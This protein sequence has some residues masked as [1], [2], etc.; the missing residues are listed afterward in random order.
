MSSV[1]NSYIDDLRSI[2]LATLNRI[3]QL[4]MRVIYGLEQLKGAFGQELIFDSD[5]NIIAKSFRF[6][7]L[8]S[9]PSTPY[10][11]LTYYNS[12]T[13][14]LYVYIDSSWAN[15]GGAGGLSNIIEDTTPQ[16]GGDLDCNTKKITGVTEIQ[17]T[18]SIL[19]KKV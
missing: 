11:G 12:A 16:L 8:A 18:T 5:G 19:F 14:I 7:N 2:V 13:D 9:A 1:P 17:T 15:I 10:K 4:R 3:E 6:E